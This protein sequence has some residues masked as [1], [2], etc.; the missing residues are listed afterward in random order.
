ML[1]VG[2]VMWRSGFDDG[3]SKMSFALPIGRCR[4]QHRFVWWL[5]LSWFCVFVWVHRVRAESPC[6]SQFGLAFVFVVF[7][8]RFVLCACNFCNSLCFWV[9]SFIH[10]IF[11]AGYLYAFGYVLRIL[12][13]FLLCVFL[14]LFC[15]VFFFFFGVLFVLS[16]EY[17]VVG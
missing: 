14:L 1:F 9:C 10:L 17:F 12:V 8:F 7:F 15:L 13:V 4:G 11:G 16:S 5:F 6:V 3:R 2:K